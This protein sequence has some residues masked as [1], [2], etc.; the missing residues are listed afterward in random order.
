MTSICPCFTDLSNTPLPITVPGRNGSPGQNLGPAVGGNMSPPET[1][2]APD[3]LH[4]MLSAMPLGQATGTERKQGLVSEAIKGRYACRL[5]WARVSGR[6]GGR[7]L[8]TAKDRALVRQRNGIGTSKRRRRGVGSLR[9]RFIQI[10]LEGAR[11]GGLHP[12]SIRERVPR[13][14]HHRPVGIARRKMLVLLGF[15]QNTFGR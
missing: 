13:S 4:A 3:R 8:K 11:G 12:D 2:S 10:K 5:A 7:R 9:W 15:D 14:H 1:G 6:A